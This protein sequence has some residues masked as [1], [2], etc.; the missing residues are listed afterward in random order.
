MQ[1]WIYS[2]KAS[3][4]MSEFL[5]KSGVVDLSEKLVRDLPQESYHWIAQSFAHEKRARRRIL[6]QS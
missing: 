3:I 2:S 6:H 4:G 1:T 5:S